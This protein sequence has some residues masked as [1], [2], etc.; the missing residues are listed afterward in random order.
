M[1]RRWQRHQTASAHMIAHRCSTA[2]LPE[3]RQARGEGRRQ[4]VVR[5]VPKAAY[6]PIGI[7]RGLSAARL[8]PETAEFGDMLVADLPRR[9]RFW[10][11]LLIE[12]RVGARSRHRSHV[13][14]EIDVRTPAS[15]STNS[16]IVLVEWPMVKKVFVSWLQRTKAHDEPASR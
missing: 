7:G 12:L 14:N 16:T 1:I 8:S 10:E 6:P 15:R 3:S 5:I 4:G 13:D 9:Q 11:A 2:P